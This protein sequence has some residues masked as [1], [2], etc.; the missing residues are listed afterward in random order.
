MR[1]LYSVALRAVALPSSAVAS[2]SR[3]RL[4]ASM[5]GI[6]LVVFV[7]ATVRDYG[8]SNDE[9]VQRTY[10]Q[11]LLNWYLS[12]FRD[13]AAF[14]YINLYLYGG[15]F[16]LISAA[17]ERLNLLNPWDLRHVLS[18]MFGLSGFVAVWKLGR[19][20][21]GERVGLAAMVLLML[22]GAWTG[23]MF[24]HTK[25]VPFAAAMIWSVYYICRLVPRLPVPPRVMVIKLGV[26]IGC[27]IGLRVGAV[28]A[29]MYL[30]VTV[31]V[32]AVLLQP[33]W[34]ERGRFLGRSV[35]SL[36]PAAGVAVV[37]MAI[38][39]PWALMAPGNLLTAATAF[40]HFAFDLD[41]ILN[42]VVYQVGD[43]PRTYF[44]EYFAI[45]VPELMLLGIFGALV[46]SPLVMVGGW[47]AL[48]RQRH[49]KEF[50]PLLPVA[51]ALA[52]PFVFV[53]VD[54]PALYNGIR[55]FT[56]VLPVAA[57][58]AA[59]GMQAL[60]R[61]FPRWR[62]VLVMAAVVGVGSQTVTLVQ[63]HPYEYLS[64]NHLVGGL[65][66]ASKKYETDYWSS[67]L[68]EAAGMLQKMAEKEGWHPRQPFPVAVCAEPEQVDPWLG[69][70]FTV[71]EDWN[72]ADFY[73]SSTQMGCDRVMAGRVIGTVVRDGVV[74]AVVKDRR[75]LPG[76]L[77]APR[78]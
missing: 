57:V 28:F 42:G 5:V 26:A 62:S 67:S 36:L 24:T 16:D 8:I 22:T 37:L 35:L 41:T 50:L 13:M 69:R 63:L 47:L 11:L 44:P 9:I 39:W 78:D 65:A 71:T 20:L 46:V 54:H 77:R 68:R 59:L 74:L 58:V 52:V 4:L 72:R 51:L 21:G 53:I 33:T 15:L 7:G 75:G 66:G 25:D 73:L 32:A 19:R 2:V 55:H 17:L 45:R 48:E 29:V 6:A 38:F 40:S 23:A 49:W 30:A 60:W 18:A 70:A 3:L 12:G 56:F 34:A 27:A 76:H 10:G 14:S 61:A 64:Y 1:E 43:V 31:T